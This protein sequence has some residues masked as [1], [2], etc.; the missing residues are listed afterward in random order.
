MKDVGIFSPGEKHQCWEKKE[1]FTR[2]KEVKAKS[3]Q[4]PL[5]DALV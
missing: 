2:T 3:N 4:L 1:H 5:E